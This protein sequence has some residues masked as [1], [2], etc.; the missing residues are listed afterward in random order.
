MTD[1]YLEGDED[2]ALRE[3]EEELRME[4]GRGGGLSGSPLG[5]V[6]EPALERG[7]PSSQALG[8]PWGLRLLER[9]R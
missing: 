4:W 2:G 1:G 6:P 5:G 8:E 3:P 7:T 9:P